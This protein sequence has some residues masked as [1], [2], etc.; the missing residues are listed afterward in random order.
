[1]QDQPLFCS[2]ECLDLV[3][4]IAV[5]G[6]VFL[7]HGPDGLDEGLPVGRVKTRR[8]PRTPISFSSISF[9]KSKEKVLIFLNHQG[10]LPCPHRGWNPRASLM[11]PA[12]WTR[13][14]VPQRRHG[15]LGELEYLW[16]SM[17]VVVP[18]LDRRWS[19]AA[20]AGERHANT[21]TAARTAKSTFFIKLTASLEDLSRAKDPPGRPGKICP[22]HR[23]LYIFCQNN[24]AFLFSTPMS[25]GV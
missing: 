20:R 18:S 17:W 10:R 19:S 14:C 25:K 8:G 13:A 24:I 2:R 22:S 7:V 1:M 3:Q 11:P 9:W 12:G 4:H 23:R 5:P 16:V 15:K 6:A 21:K